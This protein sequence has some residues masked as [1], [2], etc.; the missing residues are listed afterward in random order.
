MVEYE[1]LSVVFTTTGFLITVWVDTDFPE[2]PSKKF[3]SYDKNNM[4]VTR[5]TIVSHCQIDLNISVLLS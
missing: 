4:I 5:F 2:F 3:Q 1:S